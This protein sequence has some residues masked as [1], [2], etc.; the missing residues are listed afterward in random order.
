VGLLQKV[1]A[2]DHDGDERILHFRSNEFD[3]VFDRDLHVNTDGEVLQASRC[4]YR[5][6]HRAARFL[7]GA[8]T[9]ADGGPRPLVV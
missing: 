5:V 3:L 1:A 8:A 7:C 2:G 9:Q 4:E 6:R